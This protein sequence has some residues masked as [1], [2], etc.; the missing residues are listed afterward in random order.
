[1]AL[2]LTGPADCFVGRIRRSR[3]PANSPVALTL[4]GST[5]CFVGR[6]RRSRHPAKPFL[7]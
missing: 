3:H 5:D 7:R 2:T 6:I 4:T 1:M